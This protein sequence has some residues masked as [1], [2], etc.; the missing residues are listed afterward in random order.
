M[1]EQISKYPDVTIEVLQGAGARCGPD[2]P[3]RILTKC[4]SE[5]FCAFD[6]GEICVFGIDQIPQATQITTQ[7]LARVVC[8]HGPSSETGP[9]GVTGLD[10]GALGVTLALGI[11]IGAISGRWRRKQR[12]ENT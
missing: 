7:E 12:A 10:V 9:A 4:P 1:P 8:S 6:S 2:V 5:R 3:K 11:T